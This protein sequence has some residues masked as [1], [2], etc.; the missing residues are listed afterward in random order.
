MKIGFVFTNYNNSH[1][2]RDAV[3]S[4]LIND[5]PKE[6]AVIIVDNKSND[7]E[8]ELLREI[9]L[10]FPD[11]NLIL[12]DENLGYFKGLNK[13]IRY[14]RDN[15]KS[16]DHIVVGNN[17]LIFPS[18]F[19]DILSENR[20]IFEIYPVIS[21][22]LITLDGVHQ[23]PH[24]IKEISRFRELIY[25]IYHSS[26]FMA[27]VITMLAKKSKKITDRK[28]EEQFNVAQIIYQGYGACYILGPLFFKYFDQLWSPSF[29]MGEEFFLSKQLESINKKVYYEPGIKVC[30]QEHASVRNI[31]KKTMWQFSREAHKIYRKYVNPWSW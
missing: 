25:D 20:D 6:S 3:Q 1:F 27:Q 30:H 13:G 24:V 31:P 8:I 15:I 19:N 18:D 29:L 21:P 10:D 5:N 9:K 4:I 17:D 22:D 12:N 11:I 7:T 14:I 26:F 2:T 16:I 23:N 28:D